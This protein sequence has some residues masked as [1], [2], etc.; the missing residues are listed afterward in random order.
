MKT[1][2]LKML[3]CPKCKGDLK[4]EKTWLF[5]NHCQKKYPIKDGIYVLLP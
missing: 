1:E 3:A 4:K 2:L 5:C